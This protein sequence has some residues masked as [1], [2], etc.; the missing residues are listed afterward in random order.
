MSLVGGWEQLEETL[1]AGWGRARV[2]L[3]VDGS[4]EHAAA[5]LAPAQP[6]RAAG[7]VLRFDVARDGTGPNPNAVRRLLARLDGVGIEGALSVVSTDT[8]PARATLER[9]SLAESWDEALATV[10]ADWSDL[11]GDIDLDSSDY[12]DLAA[13]QLAPLNPRR[14]PRTLTLR[15]RAAAR[16]GYGASPG[17]VRRCL[18]RCEAKGI[19]G[20]VRVVHALSDTQPVATQGPVWQIG[21]HTV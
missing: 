15:F 9:K 6:S 5:L 4:V 3:A 20:R 16:F 21:G 11:V 17:M 13:L 12:L 18:E 2:A 8:A 14:L 19:R 10:P 7:G 1:P